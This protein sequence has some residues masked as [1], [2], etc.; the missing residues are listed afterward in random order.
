MLPP[1][2]LADVPVSNVI[3]P[4]LPDPA[5]PVLNT[6]APER[7]PEPLSAVDKLN[8]PLDVVD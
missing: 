1:T 2:P 7:P 6:R 5:V 4:L 8:A 3:D